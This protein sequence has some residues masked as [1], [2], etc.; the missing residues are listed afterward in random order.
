MRDEATTSIFSSNLASKR[1][2]RAPGCQSRV[3]L[4]PS[5]TPAAGLNKVVV[6]NRSLR[7]TNLCAKS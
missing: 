3:W 4:K 2:E 5:P 1:T 6:L 7:I